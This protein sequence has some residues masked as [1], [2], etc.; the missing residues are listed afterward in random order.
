MPTSRPRHQITETPAVEHALAV[1]ARRWPAES[2]SKLLLRLI[3]T[4][5]DALEHAENE[6]LRSRRAA[7]DASS[8]KYTY[9]FESN[10]LAQLRQDWPE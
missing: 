3:S 7:V 5:S 9:A 1:A 8:G 4:G 10:Y 6:T 2:R